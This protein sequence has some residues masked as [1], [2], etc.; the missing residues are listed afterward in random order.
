M[1]ANCFL[2]AFSLAVS[3][4]SHA[5]SSESARRDKALQGIEACLRRN[6]VP[7]RECKNLDEDIATLVDVCRQGDKT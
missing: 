5:D 1:R 3:T 2:I 6:W 7:S 4:V